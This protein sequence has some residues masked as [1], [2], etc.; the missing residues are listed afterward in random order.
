M[1][2][3]MNMTF[4]RLSNRNF[5]FFKCLSHNIQNQQNISRL[6]LRSHSNNAFVNRTHWKCGVFNRFMTNVTL[7]LGITGSAAGLY[8]YSTYSNS[9]SKVQL[10]PKVQAS[11]EDKSN[12][13]RYNIADA[14][15]IASPAVVFLRVK[16]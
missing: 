14:V 8:L 15:D 5:K 1:A 11:T 3:P 13:F 2:A 10:F 16:R 12:N 7:G 6:C 9:I 4:S